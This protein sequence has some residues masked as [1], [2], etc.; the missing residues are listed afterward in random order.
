MSSRRADWVWAAAVLAVLLVGVVLVAPP[1]AQLT[2]DERLSTH[3]TSPDGAAALYETLYEL[4]LPVARRLTPLA[5][6]DAIQGPLAILSPTDPLSP[7]EVAAVVQWVEAGGLLVLASRIGD[8]LRRELG[9]PV[10]RSAGEGRL[11]A[12]Q[13]GWVEGV[14]ARGR[15]R[16]V[17]ADTAVAVQAGAVLLVAEAETDGPAGAVAVLVGRGS[18]AVLAVSDPALFSNDGIATSGLAPVVARA[19]LE[20]T[21]AGPGSGQA[22][23][24]DE[25]HHGY[26]G[27]SLRAGLWGFVTGHPAGRAALHLSLVALLALAAASARLGNP[28]ER[29]GQARRSPVEHVA[30]LGD[31]YR[32]AG[33]DAVARRRLV[34]GFARRIG[35]ERPRAGEEG[36]FLA[37]IQ[38]RVPAG[39]EAVAAVTAGWRDEVSVLELARRI[40]RAVLRLTGE[41]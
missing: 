11:G 12:G 25:Y 29:T 26:R 14:E 2:L 24:F 20:W 16:W 33:A 37:G 30:A 9:L 27:G 36:R 1:G 6:A 8:P 17:F 15:A 40:D 32:H 19:A 21:G 7:A 41:R 5:G 13:H 23:W 10:V 34:A 39:G 18:G 38:T 35:R 31:A 4:G 22:L 28:L 3:R